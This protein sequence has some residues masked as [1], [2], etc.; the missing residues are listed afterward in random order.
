MYLWAD[1]GVCVGIWKFGN[2][3]IWKYLAGD[4]INFWINSQYSNRGGAETQGRNRVSACRRL[5]FCD[6]R[7]GNKRLSFN[8][9]SIIKLSTYIHLFIELSLATY[10]HSNYSTK[11]LSH[12]SKNI[13]HTQ[14][15][16]SKINN[17]LFCLPYSHIRHVCK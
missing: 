14:P 11:V 8:Y 4:L 1:G 16:L 17:W 15:P 13:C 2:L 10:W 5:F 6:N 3:K 12:F 7:E 9:K